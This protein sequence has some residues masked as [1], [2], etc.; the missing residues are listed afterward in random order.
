MGTGTG[1]GTSSDLTN[2]AGL[3]ND[4]PRP[5]RRKRT[6]FARPIGTLLAVVAIGWFAWAQIDQNSV[7][8]HQLSGVIKDARGLVEKAST[9]PSLKRAENFFNSEYTGTGSYPNLSDQQLHSG[10]NTDFG[11]G[12]EVSWC[13]ANAVVLQSM[14]GSGAL[15]RLLVSGK[16]VGDVFGTRPCPANLANLAPWTVRPA[17]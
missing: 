2:R 8:N 13:S 17:S 4:R 3:G 14:T 5:R 9:D 12:V 15:S 7:A 10:A 11:V 6:N 16:T 1:G